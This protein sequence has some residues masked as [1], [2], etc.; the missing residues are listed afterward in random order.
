VTPFKVQVDFDIPL[1]EGHIDADALEKL[2]S[3]LEGYFSV[4]NFSNSEKIAFT[5]LK[6]LPHVKYWWETYCEK[7]TKDDFAIFGPRPP[8]VA[9]VY[10]LKEQYYPIGNYDDRYR[11]WT[12]LHQER[13]QTVL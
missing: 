1:F 11:R 4:Q 12:T 10:A 13:G 7:H 8:W 6:A 9:F 3:F 2:L 5:L